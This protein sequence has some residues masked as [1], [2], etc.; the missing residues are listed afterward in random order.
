LG[1]ADSS[2]H[3]VWDAFDQIKNPN[4]SAARKPVFRYVVFAHDLGNKG[5]TSGTT[6]DLPGADFIVSLGHWTNQVGTTMEQGG[7]LMHELGHS[8]S[9]HHGGNDDFNNKPN[10]LSVMNY[11]FQTDGLIIGGVQ[12]N[13][14]YSRF[15]LPLLDELHLNESVG[16]NGG[17][18]VAAYGTAYFCPGADPNLTQNVFKT[19][20]NGPID[21]NCNLNSL[22]TDISSDINADGMSAT[23]LT[24]F[25]DWPTLVF[26]GGAIGQLG[27]SSPPSRTSDA[28]EITPEIDARITKPLK[29]IV[30]SPSAAKASPGS[31]VDLSF[32][33][34]NAGTNN[35]T[36]TLTP[37]SNV[38]WANLLN[39]PATLALNA[40]ATAYVTV[41]VTVPAG[42]PDGTAG[43]FRLRAVSQAAPGIQDTG[44]TT[45]TSS[46]IDTTPPLILP[47]IAGTLGNNGW[48]R[49]DVIVSWTV[50]DPESGIKSSSGCAT[51]TI[52]TDTAATTLTCSAT[53]GGG[54]S[55]SVAAT[56]K[57]DK[58]PPAI[59][60]MPVLGCTLWPPTQ[61]LVQV[62]NVAATDALSGLAPG[63]FEV[64][65]K[66][67]EPSNPDNQQIVITPNGSGGFIVQV[68]ADRLGTGAGRVYTITAA[69]ADL[70]GNR[71]TATTTC[72]V[73]HDQGN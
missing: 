4:F 69:A 45:V 31:S 3:Y 40:G 7:T 55:S 17:V 14:D 67:N 26:R 21:W 29:V 61:K 70:A 66:S 64:S 13:F 73:P 52:T 20:A 46:A 35:D 39:G 2:G 1:S 47:K 16:L 43:Q 44:G 33:V 27:A 9:L 15:R 71:S 18:T 50:S 58:T 68:Q 30:A 12:G 19:N 56:L 60:G 22:E 57:I 54:L 10:Y 72:N 28:N 6:R 25:D 51:S 49:S 53:N 32:A 23:L 65:G 38:N 8:L 37:A 62:A 63:S 5:G 24:G 42:T 48:Y 34:T 59:A 41:H 11:T 36:Y